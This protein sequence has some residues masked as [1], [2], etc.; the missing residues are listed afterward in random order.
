MAEEFV[1]EQTAEHPRLPDRDIGTVL[2][3]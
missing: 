3:A 1:T 2:G